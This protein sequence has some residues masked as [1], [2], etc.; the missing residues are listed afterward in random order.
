MTD[1]T[2]QILKQAMQLPTDE[3]RALAHRLL[4]T[5]DEGVDQAVLRAWEDLAAERMAKVRS[6]E[7]KTIPW[8][9]VRQELWAIV[10]EAN[11]R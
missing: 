6:G 10:D 3:R 8:S 11:T 9:Q 2:Q 4:D 5:C 1:Q 7:A